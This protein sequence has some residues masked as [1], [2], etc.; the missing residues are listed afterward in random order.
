MQVVVSATWKTRWTEFLGP[1]LCSKTILQSPVMFLR[2]FGP[3]QACTSSGLFRWPRRLLAVP[4]L[5]ARPARPPSPLSPGSLGPAVHRQFCLLL[6]ALPNLCSDRCLALVG[7]L[8]IM[9]CVKLS[10]DGFE[11]PL[12]QNAAGRTRSARRCRQETLKCAKN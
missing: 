4:L 6:C 8:W 10:L 2:N 3:Q 7:C 11:K 5:F 9:P 12:N 1:S